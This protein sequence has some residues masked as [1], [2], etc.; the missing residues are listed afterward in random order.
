[1]NEIFKR[2]STRQFLNSQINDKDITSLL[3]AG[4]QAPSAGNQQSW[5][6]VVIN[7]RTILDKL[8]NMS[9]YSTPLLSAQLAIVVVAKDDKELA[10]YQC[11]FQDLSAC[12]ENILLQATSLSL[13]S[14]WMAVAPYEDR[15]QYIKN[16]L[17]LPENRE[18]FSLICIGHTKDEKTQISRFD[19]SRV[20]YN[21]Y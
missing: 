4:M 6:F 12:T 10:F 15:Q 3:K 7:D 14:L 11:K 18:A 2:V 1:M 8:S 5:E 9:K 16:A 13:G 21:S 20:H 19:E 17:N